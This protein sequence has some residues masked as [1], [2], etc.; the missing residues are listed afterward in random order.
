[1]PPEGYE[2]YSFSAQDQARPVFFRGHGPGV[3]I[4]HELPGMT[5]AC[6]ELGERI[7]TAGYATHLPLLFGKP[8]QDASGRS[9]IEI[10]IR[11]ELHLFARHRSSPI[12]DWLRALCRDVHR[13]C[14]GP[15]VGL[16][17]MCLTGGFAVSLTADES[18]LAPV[19]SEPALPIFAFTQ[20]RKTALGLSAP[21][22]DQAAERSTREGIPLLGLR[23]ERD[24]LCP[25]ERFDT[26]ERRF[27][28][29]F[30]RF[31]ISAEEYDRWDIRG[32]AHSVLTRDF[33]DREGHPTRRA[34][35]RV[36]ALLEKQLRV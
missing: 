24:A 32:A 23:F 9:L 20:G 8:G 21:E 17:G 12:T 2:E 18:V 26:L 31:E 11:R 1:M 4:L 33:V 22:L 3:V 30:D 28:E 10:C 27:G 34:L 25:R 13:R 29:R 36:L 15:G 14:G 19:T 5:P 16:I 6:L 35:D 7:A